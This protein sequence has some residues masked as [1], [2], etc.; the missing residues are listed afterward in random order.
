MYN[1]IDYSL[2]DSLNGQFIVYINLSCLGALAN[3]GINTAE[4]KIDRTV[5]DLKDISIIELLREDGLFH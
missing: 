1:S 2:G 4:Y 5:N 3:M